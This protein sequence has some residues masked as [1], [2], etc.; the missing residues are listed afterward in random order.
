MTDLAGR[1]ILLTGASK[2]IG[3]ETARVLGAAGAHLIA[4]YN[5]DEA[6]ARAATSELPPQRCLRLRAD[7]SQPAAARALWDEAVAWRGRIDVL[8]NNAAMLVESPL[9]G[10]DADWD[11]VWTSS[12]ATNVLGPMALTRAATQHFRANGGGVLITM[13]SWAAQRGS[14]NPHLLAYAASKA[15][16]RAATQTIA[17]A[18]AAEGVLAYVVAPGMV[19]TRMSEVAAART[20]GE[21]AA[22]AGLAMGEWVPPAEVAELIAFLATGTC[23]HLTG[24]TLDV[25]GASYIR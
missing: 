9:D 20:G 14:G 7:L 25:N 8:V 16:V 19:R 23:R 17:R 1:T 21:A 18:H 2:G 4:H 10:T 13:S 24:A 3:A 11:D 5:S 12:Y 22:S 15:A 6:G